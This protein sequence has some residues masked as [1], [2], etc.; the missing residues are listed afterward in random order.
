MLSSNTINIIIRFN[1]MERI[2][3]FSR[4]DLA[5]YPMMGKINEFLEN[6]RHIKSLYTI[7]D[8]LELQH[9]C[10]YIDNGFFHKDW[11]DKKTEMY[12]KL[13]KEFKKQINLYFT[14]LTSELI[15]SFYDDIKYDYH[16]SFWMLVNKFKI[17][18]K[19]TTA[20]LLT[21]FKKRRFDIND[22]LYCSRIVAFFE[23]EIKAYLLADE[24]NAENLL[25]YYEQEHDREQK[26]KY[27]PKSF[28]LHDRELLIDKYLDIEDVNLN[29]VRLVES[30]KDSEFLKI[31]DKLRLKAKRLSKKLNAEHFKK[32]HVTTVAKGACLSEDQLEIEKIIM[33]GERQIYSYS[34]KKLREKTGKEDLFKNY[35]NI[36][37][38]IDFQGCIDMVIKSSRIDTFDRI[39]MKSKNEFLI[40]FDFRDRTLTGELKFELYRYFLESIDIRIE[41]V[42]QY[43][44]NDYLNS[45][46]EVDTFRLYLPNSIS[47]PLEK[48]RLIVPEFESL[49]E[50][51]RL[52]VLEG[53]ID[54]ELLQVTT[55]TSGFEKIPS[56]VKKKYVYP[57]GN[58][59]SKLR[60]Y[61]FNT[62]SI[63]FDYQKYGKKYSCF[64]EL[65]I[66][67]NMMIKN[68]DSYEKEV[69]DKF[70][71]DDYLIADLNGVVKP[72]NY[73]FFIVLGILDNNDVIN[74]YHF[75][76]YIRKEIDRMEKLKIVAF[77]G[78][79]FTKAE[80]DFFNYYLNNRFSNGLWLRNKYVH[81]TNS[82]DEEE[83]KNDYRILLK[84]MVL[85]ILKI[86]DDLRVEAHAKTLNLINA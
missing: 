8:V 45:K 37:G 56:R 82:H 10:E 39:F 15:V 53:S 40:S 26:E 13:I 21:L 70:I 78:A 38:F 12:K 58:E 83:Q 48:I 30:S 6:G 7:N 76:D 62:S 85:L 9:I 22:I 33:E 35:R 74:Y 52:F 67:E 49:I 44:V 3:F 79:L 80:R 36:F 64:Y 63:L 24:K 14:G 28:S 42:L 11:D 27:F 5:S 20:D 71:A 84:L 50:Q 86:E 68:F 31:S 4:E 46:F 34:V 1:F 18:E 55:K 81:A 43:F 19:I 2:I 57:E 72:K 51:Y 60:N 54:Y 75:P 23:P 65:I 73:T 29:Y 25:S 16:E 77:S 59:Y 61:F 32:A 69:I 41:D 17:Y 66:S 47:T